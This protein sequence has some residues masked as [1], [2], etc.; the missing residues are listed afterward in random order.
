MRWADDW[1]NRQGQ[2]QRG[3]QRRELSP[4]LKDMPT[5]TYN[6]HLTRKEY[7]L[8]KK[9]IAIALLSGVIASPGLGSV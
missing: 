5:M 4:A 3:T 9:M 7:A 8:A 6:A 1:Y 2:A